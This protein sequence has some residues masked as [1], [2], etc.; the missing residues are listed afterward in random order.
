MSLV[1]PTLFNQTLLEWAQ[2][3]GR[4]DL[5]WQQNPSPYSVHVSE[6]MLQQTQ[7][8]TVI[9]YFQRWMVAFPTLKQLAAAD[10]DHIMSLWQGL[11][12]YSRARN[13]VHAARHVLEHHQGEYPQD[14]IDLQAIP[15]VGRYTAGAIYSF[16]FNK[17]GPIVDGNVKRLFC[18]FFGIEGIPTATPVLRKLWAL[19]E[20]YT[21]ATNCR[22]YAQA[23]LDMGATRCTPKNAN[24]SA[25]PL[26]QNCNA[27]ATDRVS[28]LPT[29]KPP[30]R[31]ETRYRQ[32]Y[33]RSKQGQIWLERR[34][35]TGIWN[36]L[37][38]LPEVSG[39]KINES[40]QIIGSFKHTF[41]HYKLDAE[42][43]VASEPT[44]GSEGAWV[45][46]KQL[47][48]L[49]LPTPIRRFIEKHLIKLSCTL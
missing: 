32:F 10:D 17:P 13:L 21:P 41:S 8:V 19:A 16:A 42:V 36:G 49:G 25:C 47:T 18:R 26:Q 37:W 9:P 35:S 39:D 46:G 4:H 20:T 15:G 14:L 23:L 44:G 5:P 40:G 31:L 2:G 1:T 38:C 48:E 34:P 30:K 22:A 24:C 29:P 43:I 27:F 12:Y 7:V 6:I 28:T 11:G 33:W 45:D 3:H